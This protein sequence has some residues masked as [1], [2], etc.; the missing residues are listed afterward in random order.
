MSGGRGRRTARLISR[1]LSDETRRTL[2]G[3]WNRNDSLDWGAG[4]RAA[5]ARALRVLLEELGPLYVKVGQ[6]LATRPDMVP[7]HVRE[8]LALL[9]D[10]V[11]AR[12]FAEFETVLVAELGEEWRGLFGEIHTEVPLGSAS[13]AQVYRAVTIG[14][15]DCVIKIQRP[16]SE[17][18]VRDDMAVLRRVTGLIGRCAPHFSEVVD[19]DAM[20]SM[21]FEVMKDELDF[22]REARTMKKARKLA[23]GYPRV[24]V[25]KVLLATPRVLVQTFADGVPANQLKDD[26]LTS[27]QRKEVAYQLMEFM[28]HGY[29]IDRHFH[30]DPHPG[31]I[32]VAEDG[33]AHVIDWGM[34]GRIDR[35]TGASMIGALL[36]MARNDGAALARSWIRLGAATPWSNTAAFTSDVVR[37]VPRW[38]DASLEEV[39]FGVALME[40]GRCATRRGI[41]ISPVISVIGKSVANIEGTVRCIYPQLKF[42]DATERSLKDIVQHLAGEVLSREQLAQTFLDCVHAIATVPGE[43]QSLLADAAGGHLVV[44]ART[45]L[46]DPVS[47]GRRHR[48]PTA[49]SLARSVAGAA[50]LGWILTRK[51]HRT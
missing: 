40:L 19:I 51:K 5:R 50:V 11:S 7:D 9:N 30:A 45:N 44:R 33:T 43:L 16:G 37:L 27:R 20:A 2:R 22:T 13:L 12:P 39:Y 4:Q 34:A 32:L 18:A 17:A 15:R 31:N 29:F 25:P 42:A 47:P 10:Q 24:K 41:Q 14:G 1:A 3:R 6:I 26:Q 28:F 35:G 21:L 49:G 48:L 36:G 46:G 8:E 23:R 38:A